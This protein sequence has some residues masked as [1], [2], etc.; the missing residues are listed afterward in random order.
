MIA[1]RWANAAFRRNPNG[2]SPVV[3]AFPPTNAMADSSG[4]PGIPRTFDPA[5]PVGWCELCSLD[6]KEKLLGLWSFSRK[7]FARATYTP[8]KPP[9]R[10][11]HLRHRRSRRSRFPRLR[12]L[13]PALRQSMTCLRSF[14][15]RLLAHQALGEGF[16]ILHGNRKTLGA[17]GAGDIHAETTTIQ[18]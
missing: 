14:L 16:E 11:A 12:K 18:I 17:I 13:R 6:N 5:D 7:I 15:R 1:A 2:S 3:R 9:Q 4:S 8:S 10:Q